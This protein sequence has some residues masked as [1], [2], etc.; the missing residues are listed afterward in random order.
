M[1]Q[2][3]IPW[4]EAQIAMLLVGELELAARGIER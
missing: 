4:T 3:M 1:L 2:P